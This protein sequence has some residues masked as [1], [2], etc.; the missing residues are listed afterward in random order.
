[1]PENPN[2]IGGRFVLAI[3]DSGTSK[4]I[5]KARYFVQGF[6]NN[7][8]TNLFHDASKSKQQSKNLLIG[9]AAI[10]GYRIVSTN[11]TQAYVQSAELLMKDLHIKPS[12]EFELNANQVLK[13]LRPLYGLADSGDYLGSKLLNYL[14]EKLGMKQTAGDPERFSK[15]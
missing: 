13:L 7:K 10:F 9:L 8:M 2:I 4:E 15:C 1:M 5:C 11:V 6:R 12:A 3:K 14:K